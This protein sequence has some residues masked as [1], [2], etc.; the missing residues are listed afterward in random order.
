[1]AGALFLSIFSQLTFAF[2]RLQET[3]ACGLGTS[4][5]FFTPYF[6]D[7]LNT[8]LMMTKILSARDLSHFRDR[9]RTRNL[10]PRGNAH[11]L[12]WLSDRNLIV[13]WEIQDSAWVCWLQDPADSSST[14]YYNYHF[15]QISR[16]FGTPNCHVFSYLNINTDKMSKSITKVLSKPITKFSKESLIQ[17]RLLSSYHAL[18]IVC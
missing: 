14:M 12:S 15:V 11:V 18:F 4:W 10:D 8:V 1:M 13:L 7:E 6:E 3:I 16:G 2:V 5:Y 17:K 9:T